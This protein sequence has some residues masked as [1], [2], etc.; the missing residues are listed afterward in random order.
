MTIEKA[1]G[2][3]PLGNSWRDAQERRRWERSE[4]HWQR[5]ISQSGFFPFATQVTGKKI[6]PPQE[7]LE[8]NEKAVGG[9]A[10]LSY[11]VLCRHRSM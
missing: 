8:E 3:Y 10:T 5:Q 9:S 11:L 1:Q 6:P 4:G 2:A 7:K